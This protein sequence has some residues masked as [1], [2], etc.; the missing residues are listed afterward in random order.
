[1]IFY[2]KLIF[3]NKIEVSLV[4]FLCLQS[5]KNQKVTENFE[6]KINLVISD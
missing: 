6:K 1:M 5:K 4:V 3:P 2:K